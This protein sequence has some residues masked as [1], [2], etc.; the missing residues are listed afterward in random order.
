MTA[1]LIT[2]LLCFYTQILCVVF[3]FAT[4]FHPVVLFLFLILYFGADALSTVYGKMT[5]FDRPL[6]YSYPFVW[7]S[8][9]IANF[10]SILLI[11]AGLFINWKVVLCAFLSSFFLVRFVYC[12]IAEYLLVLPLVWFYDHL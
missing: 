5:R 9:I 6:I 3:L 10:S 4:H 7:L 2:L 1:T 12:R 11:I 8:L